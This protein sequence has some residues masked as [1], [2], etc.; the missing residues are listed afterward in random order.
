MTDESLLYELFRFVDLIDLATF[1]YYSPTVDNY[2]DMSPEPLWVQSITLGFPGHIFSIRKVCPPLRQP[3]QPTT[4]VR[5][6]TQVVPSTC[7]S[8][9]SYTQ[10]P[11]TCFKTSPNIGLQQKVSISPGSY[12]NLPIEPSS[13]RRAYSPLLTSATCRLPPGRVVAFVQLQKFHPQR[14]VHLLTALR[15]RPATH[16]KVSIESIKVSIRH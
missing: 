1:C 11:A 5:P 14:P 4:T 6:W 16:Q 8:S 3:H 13:T 12:W 15:A 7:S 10:R 2:K 9:S